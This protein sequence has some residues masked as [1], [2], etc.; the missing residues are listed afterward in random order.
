MVFVA[1]GRDR[2]LTT[3]GQLR[4]QFMPAISQFALCGLQSRNRLQS[5]RDGV[6]I[7]FLGVMLLPLAQRQNGFKCETKRF[8]A[9][10]RLRG[11]EL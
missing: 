8:H 4:A 11:A 7:M 3:A 5:K 1:L 6:G 2:S 10:S 9:R